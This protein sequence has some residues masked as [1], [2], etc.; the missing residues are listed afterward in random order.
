MALKLGSLF[1]D[2][3]ADTSKL[4]D[5]M[6]DVE[7]QTG[8][9]ERSFS[10]LGTVIK[11]VAAA[12]SARRILMIADNMRV[13]DTR[14]KNLTKTQ[15]EYERSSASLNQTANDTGQTF[16]DTVVF[17]ERATRALED[18]GATN[19][20]VLQFTD[21]IQKLGVLGG[22]SVDEIANG[23]RQLNQA[24]Q[25]GIVR[26]EEFNSI[27]ENTPMIAQ[28]IAD[29]LGKTTGELRNMVLAGAL[30]SDKVFAAIL[31]QTE[32]VNKE[33]K[34]F[35][36][37]IAQASNALLNEFGAT[38]AIIDKS[39]GGLSQGVA[40]IFDQM[41]EGL[42][43]I[44]KGMEESFKNRD[45]DATKEK[46]ATLTNQT[47]VLS[48][49]LFDVSTGGTEGA[50]KL[51]LIGMTAEEAAAKVQSN[52]KEIQKLNAELTTLV[53]KRKEVDQQSAESSAPAAMVGPMGESEEVK[54]FKADELQNEFLAI[55]MAY[56]EHYKRLAEITEAG[57]QERTDLEKQLEAQKNAEI[58]ALQAQMV[59]D[60]L[61]VLNTGL[62]QMSGFLDSLNSL[63]DRSGKK[64]N[65]IM[66]AAFLAQKAVQVVSIVANAYEAGS[67]I[68]AATANP[69][70]GAAVTKL[71]LA[72][73]A[74]VA[75]LGVGEAVGG[76]QQGGPVSAN[77]LYDV[78]ENGE[79]EMFV[80]GNKQFL[81]TG[82]KGGKVISNANMQGSGGGSANVTVVN[83]TGV[84]ASARTEYI[85]RD[86][87]RIILDAQEQKTINNAQSA[88]ATGIDQNSGPVNES[89]NRNTQTIRRLS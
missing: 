71:G 9:A 1:F 76:R 73:A 42:S 20:Q 39:V 52:Y 65:A 55:E 4:K 68:T 84:Q 81:M 80:S 12:E 41:A 31:E 17:F 79:A 49:A 85:S 5:G 13:L 19:P 10:K 43:K 54:A 11:A 83:N 51:F 26:A 53:K 29:N 67:K 23:T 66:K 24:L 48:R 56:E 35:P 82:S 62:S 78:T 30:T 89:L 88:I 32:N 37:S 60:R 47:E 3:F 69:A 74:I 46:L 33:F 40:G 57:T 14:L 18:L 75:G 59:A 22:N 6:G 16:K 77:S 63:L 2:V 8:K 28:A 38:I 27:I 50:K 87:L 15:A 44:R 7:K 58:S 64:S 36:R 45:I 70:A 86:E 25:G 34:D 61:N 21:T 72:N